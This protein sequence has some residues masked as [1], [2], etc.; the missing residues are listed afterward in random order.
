MIGRATPPGHNNAKDNLTKHSI[1]MNKKRPAASPL[2]R[3]VAVLGASLGGLTS[4]F[5]MGS[6]VSPAMTAVP[7]EMAGPKGFEPSTTWLKARRSA[8]LS[9]GPSLTFN[10][11]VFQTYCISP[12]YTFWSNHT[13]KVLKMVR[14]AGFEP[15]TCGSTVRRSTRLNYRR[16]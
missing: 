6:G 3:Q 5:G 7:N 14:R 10:L 4:E 12:I 16:T 1:I 2:S 9:Y 15:A 11:C 13:K 8:R